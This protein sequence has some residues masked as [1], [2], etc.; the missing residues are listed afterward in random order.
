MLIKSEKEMQ[1]VGEEYGAKLLQ[2]KNFPY[3][4]ELLGDVGA[5]KTTFT[6]GLAKGLGVEDELSS[7]SFTISRGYSGKGCI[8]THFDFYRIADPGLMSEDLAEAVEADSSVTVV[9][10]GQS[11]Q[12]ILPESRAKI[13]ITYI[14]E[15]TRALTIEESKK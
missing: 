8:L 12:A 2:Q 4:I 15:N 3:V 10:W 11:I 14:D 5:G 1:K 13:T 9:E 7:P 6:R